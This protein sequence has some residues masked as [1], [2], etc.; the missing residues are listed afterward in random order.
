MQ[1]LFKLKSLISTD[2]QIYCCHHTVHN[3]IFHHFMLVGIFE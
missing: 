2:Y 1:I 3:K